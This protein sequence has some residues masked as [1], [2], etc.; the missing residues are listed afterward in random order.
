MRLKKQSTISP[1]RILLRMT[2]YMPKGMDDDL[3]HDEQARWNKAVAE[4]E[5][6]ME[7]KWQEANSDWERENGL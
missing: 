2:D 3:F 5:E 6:A 4:W 1:Q 7:R